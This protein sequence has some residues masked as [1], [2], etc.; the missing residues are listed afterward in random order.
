[1]LFR[2]K[3]CPAILVHKECHLQSI[4]QKA[5]SF[6]KQEWRN[7]FRFLKPCGYEKIGL[8][9]RCIS[10]FPSCFALMLSFSSNPAPLLYPLFYTFSF[11][12]SAFLF[13]L[14][15]LHT[16]VCWFIRF[17]SSY[18]TLQGRS[19]SAASFP[20]TS[21]TPLLLWWSMTSPVSLSL[22]HWVS[23]DL[24]PQGTV[25]TIQQLLLGHGSSS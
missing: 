11:L 14:F 17:G 25:S 13:P 5:G 6:R 23:R 15:S 8:F 19:A 24:C 1:M 12:C 9:C 3:P 10:P 4:L 16:T 7:A 20:A 2:L 21:E 22:T 18:G